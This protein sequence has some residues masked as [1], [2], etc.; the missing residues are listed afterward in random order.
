MELV[1]GDKLWSSWSLRPW[2]VLKRSSLPF[3]ETTVRLRRA[4]TAEAIAAAGSPSGKIPILKDGDLL[5]WDSLAICEHLADRVEGLWPSDPVARAL[6]RAAAAEMHSGFLA[7]R[8]EF[9]MDLARRDPRTPSPAAAEELRRIVQLWGGLR[10]RFGAAGPYLLGGWS[11]ADAM[12]T[13][14]ATRLESYGIDLSAHGDD[15]G[16]AAAY[17]D[18]L[19]AQPDYLEWKAAA[20]AGG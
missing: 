7:V 1:I 2:L 4:D 9:S 18:A 3:T 6:G 16:A 19:L 14:V 8:S 20:L 10:R 13:P 17:R 12:Y 15:D 11:I 5:V